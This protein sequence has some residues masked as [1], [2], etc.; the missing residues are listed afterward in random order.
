MSGT[1]L[2]M[3]LNRL[4][5]ANSS[6]RISGVHRSAKISLAIATGQN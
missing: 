5:P 6:R 2:R 3:A 1:P 4:A